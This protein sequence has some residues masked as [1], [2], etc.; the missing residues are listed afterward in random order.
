MLSKAGSLSRINVQNNIDQKDGI[1]N[2][3]FENYNTVWFATNGNGAVKYN[4]KNENMKFYK[5][6]NKGFGAEKNIVYNILKNKQGDTFIGTYLSGLNICKDGDKFKN[7]NLS[8]END[9]KDNSINIIFE[10]SENNI[11]IGTDKGAAIFDV[12]EEKIYNIEEIGKNKIISSFA[13]DNKKNL[14][15]GT[16]N[17]GLIKY[18]IKDKKVEKIN[19]KNEIDIK[20]ICGMIKVLLKKK[21]K[22]LEQLEKNYDINL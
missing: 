20:N 1:F 22:Q 6:G 14:W 12:K 5:N 2:I 11:W 13:E 4:I 17:E 16:I 21:L 3:Y 9:I 18:N 19:S 15:I 8:N 10:D 7:Y